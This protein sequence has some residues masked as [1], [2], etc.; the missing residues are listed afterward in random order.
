[1]NDSDSLGR[2]KAQLRV[3]NVTR[4]GGIDTVKDGRKALIAFRKS[5]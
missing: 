2:W 3:K 4:L 1:M 5:P